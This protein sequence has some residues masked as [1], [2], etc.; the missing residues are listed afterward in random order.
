KRLAKEALQLGVADVFLAGGNG[1]QVFGALR[2]SEAGRRWLAEW[3]RSAD[4]WF[5]MN[6]GD[7]FQHHHRA[8]IDDPTPV[9]S[10]LADYIQ[11]LQRGENLDRDTA[12]LRAERDRITQGYREL[13]ATEEEKQAF[14][15]ILALTRDVYY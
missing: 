15:Q 9:V 6:T 14:D 1:A 11:R 12:S 13:L 5:Y 4:P 3:E 8:W 10:V 2:A 7:G